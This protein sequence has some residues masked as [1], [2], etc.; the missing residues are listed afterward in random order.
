M[1]P[2][3]YA[4]KETA[5]QTNGTAAGPKRAEIKSDASGSGIPHA[6]VPQPGVPSVSRSCRISWFVI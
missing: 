2:A 6:P 1:T 4:S 5:G 3:N